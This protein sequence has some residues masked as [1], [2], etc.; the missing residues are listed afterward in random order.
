MRLNPLLFL[1]LVLLAVP[2]VAQM[3]LS[4]ADSAAAFR[5]AGFKLSKGTWRACDAPPDS[6]YTP[7][8]IEQVRD[9]DGDGRPEAIITEGSTFCYGGDE[10]G[11][12]IVSKQS[13][14]SWKLITSSEGIPTVL[15]SKGVKGWPDIEIGGQGFCFPVQRWNGSE[16]AVVRFQYEGKACKP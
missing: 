16:Y 5:A 7:G 14:K 9:L 8:R 3:Q 11:F 4:R 10:V 2:A 6:I 12:A 1:P 13:D 15:N